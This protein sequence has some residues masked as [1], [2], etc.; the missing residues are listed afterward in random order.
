MQHGA[1]P[2]KFSGG[3]FDP[4]WE[5]AL[6]SFGFTPLRMCPLCFV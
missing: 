5:E 2:S 1:L 4:I 6:A 3:G